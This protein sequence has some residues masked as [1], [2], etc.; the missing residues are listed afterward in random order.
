MEF[1]R[2]PNGAWFIREWELTAPVGRVVLGRSDTTLNSVK[3]RNGTVR[4]VL[5]ATGE[6]IVQFDSVRADPAS[7]RR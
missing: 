1:T 3:V 6:V 5:S 2:L 4:E 7:I